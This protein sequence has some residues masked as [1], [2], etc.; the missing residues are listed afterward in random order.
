MDQSAS[1]ERPG[2]LRTVEVVRCV[3]CGREKDYGE[4][5]WLTV[6]AETRALRIHYCPECMTDLVERAAALPDD[7]GDA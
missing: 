3:E 5:G 1:G 7:T 2:T 4:R 6:L